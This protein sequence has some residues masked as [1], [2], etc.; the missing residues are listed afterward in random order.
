MSYKIIFDDIKN[1]KLN[2]LY[3]LYGREKYLF[4]S[5]INS[6]EKKYENNSFKEFNFEIIDAGDKSVKKPSK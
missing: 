6:L 2:N 3:L 1:K 4:D 5:I